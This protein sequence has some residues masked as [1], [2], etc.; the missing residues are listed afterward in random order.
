MQRQFAGSTKIP[1]A[2]PA[3]QSPQITA[4]TGPESVTASNDS[5]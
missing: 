1:K 4:G 5:Q 2:Q 3:D